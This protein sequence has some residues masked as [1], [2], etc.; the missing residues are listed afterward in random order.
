MSIRNEF[1]SE[2]RKKAR[3]MA[4]GFPASTAVILMALKK[5]R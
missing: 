2:T 4:L 1:G 5:Q 3:L